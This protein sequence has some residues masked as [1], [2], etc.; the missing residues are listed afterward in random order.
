MPRE[1]TGPPPLKG[2]RLH[3]P[4]LGASNVR[5][6]FGNRMICF[7]N[8]TQRSTT[9]SMKRH[10]R[11][12][13]WFLAP[14]STSGTCHSFTAG[15]IQK[16]K[17]KHDLIGELY[18]CKDVELCSLRTCKGNVLYQ[19]SDIIGVFSC[20][21]ALTATTSQNRWCQGRSRHSWS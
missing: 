9:L 13:C 11:K 8:T 20:E 10:L 6:T 12:F 19:H 5:G 4:A 1:F 18:I 16:G 17:G 3:R 15:D 14:F 21:P 2:V 7:A